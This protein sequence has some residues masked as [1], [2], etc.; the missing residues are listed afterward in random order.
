MFCN[1]SYSKKISHVS[2]SDTSG[3]SIYYVVTADEKGSP[4][5]TPG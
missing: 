2:F 4:F 5:L 3:V 1:L